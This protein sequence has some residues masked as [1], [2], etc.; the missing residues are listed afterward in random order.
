VKKAVRSLSPATVIASIALFVSLGGVSYGVAAGSIDSREIENN[1]VKTEDVRNSGLTG[2][3][4]RNGSLQS[5]DLRDGAVRGADVNDRSLG[6]EDLADNTLGDREI[7]EPALDIQRLAGVDAA[8]YVKSVRRVESKTAND[9]A[10]PKSTPPATC[11][12]GKKV[13]GGGARVVAPAGTPVALT[14][15]GPAGNSWGASAYATAPTGNW[16]LVAVAIC[17]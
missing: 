5:R 12:K 13:L 3:D 7:N 17:G 6:G 11:P 14:A 8:R 4:V 2:R 15:S 9:P 10:T 1:T 16:Q